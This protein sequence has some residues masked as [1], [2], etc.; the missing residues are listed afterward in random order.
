MYETKLLQI[1]SKGR[2]GGRVK[3]F[4]D[5]ALISRIIDTIDSANC[6]Q[7][8][9]SNVKVLE[10]GTGTG[11][12]AELLLATSSTIQYLG[13][14]PTKSLRD[15]T[16]KTLL[17]FKDRAEIIDGTLPELH[18]VPDSSFDLC[19]MLHLLEH[20]PDHVSAH[21][22]LSAVSSRLKPGGRVVIVCPNIFDY[23]KYF[24]DADWSHAYPTTTKRLRDLGL[25][26]GYKVIEAIDLRCNSN[27][28]HIRLVL[29][30]ISYIFPVRLL[31]VLGNYVLKVPYIGMGLAAAVLWRNSW[32]VLEKSEVTNEIGARQSVN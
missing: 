27:R 29:R 23:K 21:A 5:T 13:V 8:K 1:E 11:R 16:R 14:E 31:N 15:A 20:A 6:Q 24:Y 4:I 30:C 2:P 7:S 22:W 9:K 28:A 26:T 32:I 18:D 12:I 10:I 19:L 3:K 25:D 17:E